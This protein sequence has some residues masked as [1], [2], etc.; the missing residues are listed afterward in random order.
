MES[1][2]WSPTY[3]RGLA[4]TPPTLHTFPECNPPI[5]Q[6]MDCGVVP[7]FVRFLT[8]EQMPDLQLNAVR[9]LLH[10][11]RVPGASV[12]HLA[13]LAPPLG[14]FPPLKI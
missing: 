3:T 12:L 6:V 4:L 5:Q 7:D 1:G 10:T 13:S 8:F 9:T 11:R 2:D 14:H